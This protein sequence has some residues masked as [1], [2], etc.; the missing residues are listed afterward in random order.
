MFHV[1]ILIILNFNFIIITLTLKDMIDMNVDMHI[2]HMTP[3][4]LI[5]N[6]STIT[7]QSCSLEVQVLCAE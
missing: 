5:K 6:I 4:H 3:D 1:F 2:N 7:W